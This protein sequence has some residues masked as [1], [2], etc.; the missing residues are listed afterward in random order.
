MII[1]A[2]LYRFLTQLAM[3]VMFVASFRENALAVNMNAGDLV[4]VMFGNDTEFIQNLG[5]ATKLLAPGTMTTFPVSMSTLSAVAGTNPVNWA[6][7]GFNQ[8]GSSIIL[9]A[10]SSL[11]PS[12]YT[13]TQLSHVSIANPT[14]VTAIWE[15]QSSED[16]L[17]WKLLPASDVNSFTHNF[18]TSGT[19]AG[20]FPVSMQGAFGSTLN[21][22]SGDYS[23]KAITLLGKGI[24]SADGSQLIICTQCPADTQ[25]T[26]GKINGDVKQIPGSMEITWEAAL[27]LLSKQGFTVQQADPKSR[28]I[29][30]SQKKDEIV[31]DKNYSHTVTLNLTFRPVSD[32]TTELIVLANESTEFHKKERRWWKLFGFI[33]LIPI[34]ETKTTVVDR[35][36]V[37]SA[38]FY[39]EFLDALERAS[40]E[41]MKAK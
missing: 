30:A 27:E 12:A 34:N 31:E 1:K 19:L 35:E 23:T 16:G 14:N 40:Q 18:G 10:G 6:L 3:A 9:L 17:S 26:N 28:V 41:K 37:R 33:P 5:P 25:Q 13:P 2:K 7:I 20:G 38:A 21:V 15:A 4:F 24:L 39:Q 8:T 36:P 29:Q 32:Q 22:I 11:P